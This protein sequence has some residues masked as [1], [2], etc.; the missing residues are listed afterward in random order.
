[1]EAWN[2]EI[3]KYHRDELICFILGEDTKAPQE[4]V[5]STSNPLFFFLLYCGLGAYTHLKTKSERKPNQGLWEKICEGGEE[6]CKFFNWWRQFNI[7]GKKLPQNEAKVTTEKKRKNAKGLERI[8][9]LEKVS[10]QKQKTE[11]ASKVKY[12]KWGLHSPQE[13]WQNLLPVSM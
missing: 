6:T 11:K 5:L 8:I 1:M 3:G 10:K 2:F 7:K 9:S 4:I 12:N 13:I